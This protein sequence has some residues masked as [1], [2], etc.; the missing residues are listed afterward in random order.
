MRRGRSIRGDIG[1]VRARRRR[2]PARSRRAART[3][4]W[5]QSPA[6]VTRVDLRAT[7]V[8]EAPPRENG[9]EP[10]E[11]AGARADPSDAGSLSQGGGVGGVG[12]EGL[13]GPVTDPGT[14]A[15][16]TR[17]RATWVRRA[18]RC[19]I[20]TTRRWA[21]RMLAPL[22]CGSGRTND[23]DGIKITLS[24][25]AAR[26]RTWHLRATA[27]LSQT[28]ADVHPPPDPQD[29]WNMAT[30][31]AGGTTPTGAIDEPHDDAC[32]REERRRLRRSRRRGTSRRGSSPAPSI[33]NWFGTHFVKNWVNTDGAGHAVGAAILGIRLGR[34]APHL[35]VGQ[36]SPLTGAASPWT[37][38]AAASVTSSR[39]RGSGSS[40]S[41]SKARPATVSASSTTS[42]TSAP[43]RSLRRGCRSKGRSA[44]RR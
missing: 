25:R 4:G 10:D 14:A 2:P 6:T 22:P 19:S 16:S 36:D 41:P 8:R 43:A 40:R 33:W 30:N 26:S 3:A 31:T 11:R 23:A 21:A 44:G 1:G 20:R 18:R 24:R 28:G 29:V 7:G 32:D 15:R 34:S 27:V 35:V 12:G 13:G 37:T 5:R 38:R 39:R 9:L 42:R 17:R